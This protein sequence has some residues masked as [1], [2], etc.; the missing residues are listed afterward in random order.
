MDENFDMAQRFLKNLDPGATSWTFQT[1]DDSKEKDRTLARVFNGTLEAHYNTLK[2]LNSRGAGVF[3][4]VQQTDGKGRKKDNITGLRTL[5]F[6]YDGQNG[7]KP[8]DIPLK[9]SQIIN[10]SPPNKYHLYYLADEIQPVTD[11]ILEQYTQAMAY[12]IGKGSDPN[13]KDIARVLRLP[14]FHNCKYPDKPLVTL[15][16]GRCNAYSWHEMINVFKMPEVELDFEDINFFM[17]ETQHSS[18]PFKYALIASALATIDPGC[19][20]DTWLKI[21]MALHHASN[22]GEHGYKIFQ[23]W[24]QNAHSY[25]Q[26]D[27]PKQWHRFRQNVKKP[28]TIKTL[29]FLAREEFNWDG[30]YNPELEDINRLVAA[31]RREVFDHLNRY[32]S[33]LRTQKGVTVVYK[34]TND[35]NM[36]TYGV[37]PA[38]QAQTYFENQRV[39][40]WGNMRQN[41]T[42]SLLMKN[43][44]TEW[45]GYPDRKIFQGLEFS[46]HKDITPG[47]EPL[48]LPD[49]V[50]LNTYFGLANPGRMGSFDA[51]GRH[52][53]E[54]WCR[55]RRDDYEY[56]MNWFARMFQEP[57]EP[58]LTCVT[59][60]SDRQGAGKNCIVDCLVDA[61]GIYGNTFST[62]K[63]ITGRFNDQLAESIFVVL[64]EAVWSN[65]YQARSFLKSA[66]TS[67]RIDCERKFENARTIRNC[68]HIMCL[69]NADWVV[70]I[71]PG[72]RRYYI[73]ECDDKY[74]NKFEY[75][76]PLRKKIKEGEG[77]AF[78]WHLRHRDIKGFN[79]FDFPRNGGTRANAMIFQLDS[80]EA[81]ILEALEQESLTFSIPGME[82]VGK[83]SLTNSSNVSKTLVYD[84]YHRYFLMSSGSKIGWIIQN[85]TQFGMKARK[86]FPNP[87]IWRLSSVREEGRPVG[88][89]MAGPLFNLRRAYDEYLGEPRDWDIGSKIV[90]QPYSIF[91]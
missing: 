3:I 44:F 64:E 89:Y 1:F 76:D 38:Q 7:F 39:P 57:G 49:T 13:A 90:D 82:N 91:D 63:S 5:F 33:I 78:I 45:L 68:T 67:K 47:P 75:F 16:P 73:L 35:L 59:V 58:G 10:T 40:T 26:H 84:A 69:S 8:S 22:G 41:G 36:L 48:L 20:Y 66:I 2:N 62:Q 23:R 61:F 55:N 15:E 87:D 29:F 37:M 81:F 34:C 6:E 12:M 24:S 79:P 54:V 14:G 30:L 4:T 77:D 19:D 52:I 27:W 11:G 53:L 72:D 17:G 60:R 42:R 74:A 70:P 9:P 32:Y 21:G 80:V 43:I 88:S 28:I 51:I 50:K 25:R 85:K 83:L 18:D 71:E 31:E 65:S 86:I 56:I 46:P